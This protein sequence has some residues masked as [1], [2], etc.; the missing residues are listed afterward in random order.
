MMTNNDFLR[1]R[2]KTQDTVACDWSFGKAKLFKNMPSSTSKL[3]A[4]M[5]GH[6]LTPQSD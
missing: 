6:L 2:Q 5:Q 4:H 3:L 1:V